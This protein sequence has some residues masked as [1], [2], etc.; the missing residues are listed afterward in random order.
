[1]LLSYHEVNILRALKDGVE[2]AVVD[3]RLVHEH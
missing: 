2:K 3:I 1:M